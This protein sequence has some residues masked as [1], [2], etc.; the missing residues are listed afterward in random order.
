M[1]VGCKIGEY[2]EY[3]DGEVRSEVMQ[4]MQPFE[5]AGLACIL[6]FLA[7]IVRLANKNAAKRQ[8]E[9]TLLS[10]TPV[11]PCLLLPL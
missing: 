5:W 8:V 4:A 2:E 7:V 9:Q 6:L 10:H 3:E 1:R 11:C